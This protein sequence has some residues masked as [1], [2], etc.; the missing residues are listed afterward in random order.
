MN[1]PK[2]KVLET[3]STKTHATCVRHA[4]GAVERIKSDP[5]C[6]SIA[7]IVTKVDGT[8]SCGTAVAPGNR[9]ALVGAMQSVIL[10]LLSA[11]DTTDEEDPTD[12]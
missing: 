3:R 12:E 8:V 6:L 2:V 4:E 9:F 11:V 10:D 5:N 1:D 7:Y